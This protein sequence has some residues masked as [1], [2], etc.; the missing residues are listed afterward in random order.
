M[1]W[2][3]R[4]AAIPFRA[5]QRCCRQGPE[6]TSIELSRLDAVGNQQQVS[7]VGALKLGHIAFLC[8]PKAMPSSTASARLPVSDGSPTFSCSCAAN[9]TTNGDFIRDKSTSPHRYELKDFAHLQSACDILA[10][11]DPIAWGPVRLGP[12]QRRDLP[13]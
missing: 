12:A 13:P 3:A 2:R 9:A 11:T 8:E 5:H 1:A 7:G 4:S 6:G 10:R